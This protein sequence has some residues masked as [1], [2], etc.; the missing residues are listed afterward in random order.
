MT[1]D[2]PSHPFIFTLVQRL[3]EDLRRLK[4]GYEFTESALRAFRQSAAIDGI[5]DFID[6]EFAAW[7]LAR[8]ELD[9]ERFFGYLAHAL[10]VHNKLRSDLFSLGTPDKIDPEPLA[11]AH[12]DRIDMGIN[13]LANWLRMELPHNLR[14][15]DE[16]GYSIRDERWGVRRHIERALAFSEAARQIFGEPERTDRA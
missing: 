5:Y 9:Q 12:L 10:D 1:M 15:S 11:E 3:N 14:G 6:V 16:G 7:V 2:H 8:F 4:Q 13:Y